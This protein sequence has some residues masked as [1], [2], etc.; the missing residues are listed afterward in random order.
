MILTSLLAKLPMIRDAS[1]N[2]RKTLS[3]PSLLMP[4]ALSLFVVDNMKH[5]ESPEVDRVLEE[6][7]VVTRACR[8]PK[9]GQSYVHRPFIDPACCTDGI[10]RV[11]VARCQCKQINR[12]GL[13]WVTAIIGAAREIRFLEQSQ[14]DPS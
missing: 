11:N 5:F 3:L 10:A 8:F 9:R 6:T 13:R 12:R 14:E 1:S 7:G 2:M 4:L